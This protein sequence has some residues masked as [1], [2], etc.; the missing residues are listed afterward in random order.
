MMTKIKESR[1]E[2]LLNKITPILIELNSN[3]IKPGTKTADGL[4]EYGCH[5]CSLNYGQNDKHDPSCYYQ[6][7]KNALDA[8][9]QIYQDASLNYN[10]KNKL[11]TNEEIKSLTDSRKLDLVLTLVYAPLL[12]YIEPFDYSD[13]ANRGVICE[14]C[15]MVSENDF[16]QH[17]TNCVRQQLAQIISDYY[18][19]SI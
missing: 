7:A 5:Y 18:N 11:R 4:H 9:N 19:P 15:L 13:P 10:H 16:M 2:K 3:W 8:W 17:S 12:T 6:V 14:C 1:Q